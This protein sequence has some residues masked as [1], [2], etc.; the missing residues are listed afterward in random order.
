[1]PVARSGKTQHTHLDVPVRAVR[2]REEDQRLDRGRFDALTR[3][4]FTQH[5]RRAALVAIF[6]AVVLGHISDP[7]TGRPKRKRRDKGKER[8]RDQQRGGHNRGS[9]RGRGNKQTQ[10]L[11]EAV[12][13][14]CCSRNACVPGPGK[15]LG[16]CC[17]EDA[18]L[19]GQN[20]KG[21][22]L[23]SANFSR[24]ILTNANF[25]SANLGKTCF[26]DADV[27]GAK[28]NGANTGT[29]IFCRT[30]IDNGENNSGCAKGTPCCPTCDDAHP[31][32]VGQV[33]CD[34]RCLEG[35]C[36]DNG[37]Q[38]TCGT[39]ELCCDRVCSQGV[40]CQAADCPNEICQRRTCEDHQCVY[41]SV[42]D[43]P[44][45]RC[46]APH[47]CCQDA[48]GAPLCCPEGATT[49]DGGGFCC[50]APSRD[51][52]C[53]VGTT[54]PKCGEITNICDQRINCGP[55]AERICQEGNCTGPDNTCEYTPV[56]GEPGPR[57]PTLCCRDSSEN[58]ECCDAGATQCFPSGGCRCANNQD[59]PAGEACCDGACETA[60][61]ANETTFGSEGDGDSQFERIIGVA[62]SGNEQ[63]SWVVDAGNT[64]VSVW[65]RQTNGQW[66]HDALFGSSGSGLGQFNLPF[67]VAVAD[68]GL[69]AFVGDQGSTQTLEGS[70][71]SVWR[72]QFDGSWTNPFS[73]GNGTG[74][75]ADQFDRPTGVAVSGDGKTLWVADTGNDRI[76][77]WTEDNG[78]W[79]PLTTFGSE[80]TGPG[81][82]R[83]AVGVAVSGDGQTAWVIDRMNT[84]V[85]VWTRQANGDWT[86]ATEFGSFGDDP[87]QWR[88]P[89]SVAV[90]ADGQTAFVP[91]LGHDRISI[92]TRQPN[93]EWSHE[94]NIGN[95]EG[96]GRDQ[97]NGPVGIAAAANGRAIWVSDQ[98]NFRVSVW[99]LSGCLV[100]DG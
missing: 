93:G 18:N 12:P 28:F 70:R 34:G 62:V 60:I 65:S 76:S 30:Q 4:V 78:F 63:T 26:V 15:H 43:R 40:C 85:S 61:W 82:F 83:D 22:N 72:K 35:D 3:L 11:G 13:G 67:G 38:S 51:E 49:C 39:G 79:T 95:G 19:A 59:C 21:A 91:D 96:S 41:T 56:F 5:S 68:D 66:E 7:A 84:V 27:T 33:C 16:K 37:E 57:C 90:A 64:R 86:F 31:C 89:L 23:G 36:C 24:A 81:Q 87:D 6:D 80:G 8:K 32:E 2:Q 10:T 20:F 14:K 29:A 88:G 73:L 55:C 92:W 58:P 75:G 94:L 98:S 25:S 9:G 46:P 99:S 71:V 50:T 77:V 97:F 1:M 48:Q 44:G 74:D 47:V 17:F 53:A 52:T 45:P 69:T 100:P 42:F 54:A